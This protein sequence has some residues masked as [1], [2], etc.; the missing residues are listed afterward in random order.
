MIRGL[1][2]D[3]QD[4]VTSVMISE[5]EILDINLERK[6][7]LGEEIMLSELQ[8]ESARPIEPYDWEEG[9]EN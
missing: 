1:V 6:S 2:I 3:Y 8:I 7:E 9:G 4:G 5:E